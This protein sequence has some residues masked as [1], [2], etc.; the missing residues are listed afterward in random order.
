MFDFLFEN[1]IDVFFYFF[2]Y[3]KKISIFIYGLFVCVVLYG[4]IDS[5]FDSEKNSFRILELVL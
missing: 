3:L 2:N 4:K 1:F 5:L